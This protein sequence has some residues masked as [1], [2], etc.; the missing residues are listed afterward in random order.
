MASAIKETVTNMLSAL[1]L[2]K[3][4][5]ETDQ[6]PEPPS[7][8]EHKELKE[9][10]DNAK[11]DH[12]FAFWDQLQPSEQGS[13]YRGGTRLAQHT[14]MAGPSSNRAPAGN[15]L[16]KIVRSRFNSGTSAAEVA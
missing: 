15:S 6:G 16:R 9:K 1:N 13:L 7:D 2:S 8:E 3:K 5:E 4:E 11:Q 10:Y 14:G 12:V